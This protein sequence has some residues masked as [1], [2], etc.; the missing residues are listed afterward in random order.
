MINDM[1]MLIGAIIGGALGGLLI[2][3]SLAIVVFIYDF[4]DKIKE[5]KK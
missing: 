3:A 2:M 1:Q 5:E 4:V